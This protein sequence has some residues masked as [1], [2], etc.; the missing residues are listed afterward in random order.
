MQVL[1]GGVIAASSLTVAK[2]DKLLNKLPPI[3]GIKRKKRAGNGILLMNSN[4]TKFV[5]ALIWENE[6][7]E[8]LTLEYKKNLC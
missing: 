5:D 1:L 4:K 8:I 6:E 3:K 2:A 7:E